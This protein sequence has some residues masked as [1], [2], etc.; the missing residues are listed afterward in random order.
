MLC[1]LENK[2]LQS[3]M[4]EDDLPCLCHCGTIEFLSLY[5]IVSPRQG[6]E[7]GRTRFL[8]LLERITDLRHTVFS[9]YMGRVG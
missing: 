2:L 4:E 1:E 7:I 5:C 9:S 8:T 6:T 3:A